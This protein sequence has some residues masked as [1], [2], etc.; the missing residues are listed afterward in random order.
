METDQDLVTMR[1]YYTKEFLDLFNSGFKLYQE[2]VWLL[3]RD[4]LL[5]TRD[6]LGAVD[7]PSSRIL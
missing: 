5:K 2:G 4:E 1:K 7:T 3:A 6:M